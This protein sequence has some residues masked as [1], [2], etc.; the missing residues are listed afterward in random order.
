MRSSSRGFTLVELSI[1]LVIIGLLVGGVLVGQ[2]VI[3]SSEIKKSVDQMQELGTSLR[4]FKNEYQAHPGDFSTAQN[5]WGASVP[6][7]NGNGEIKSVPG[8]HEEELLWLHLFRAGLWPQN[9]SGTYGS[10]HLLGVNIPE[11]AIAGSG[12]RFVNGTYF[13]RQGIYLL[14]AQPVPNSVLSASVFTPAEALTIDT[15]Y[16]DGKPLDGVFFGAPGSENATYC[17]D[18]LTRLYKTGDQDIECTFVRW[19]DR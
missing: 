10:G 11:A 13:S 18:T 5:F 2:D 9:L 14:W 6:N 15:K 16:D 19:L 1:V 17:V 8:I 4:L 3:R 7:G 12:L